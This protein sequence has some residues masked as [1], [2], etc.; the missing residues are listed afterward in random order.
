MNNIDWS[1][2][3]RPQSLAVLVPLLALLALIAQALQLAGGYT[4]SGELATALWRAMAAALL[5]AFVAVIDILVRSGQHRAQRRR[6]HDGEA[7][8]VPAAVRPGP[9]GELGSLLHSSVDY[10]G[11]Y[12][13]LQRGAPGL[14]PQCSGVLYLAGESD[15]QFAVG[16][17]W[18][19]EVGSSNAFA[20]GDCWAVRKGE[21]QFTARSAVA[22]CPHLD[23]P[24]EAPSLCVPVKAQGSVLGML[25]LVG[26]SESG[27]VNGLRPLATDVANA[28]GMSIANLKLRQTLR[29]LSVRDEHT[30]VFNR[31][32]LEESLKREIA[33]AQRKSRSLGVAICDVDGFERFNETYGREAGDFALR[34]IAQ[35]MNAKIRSS[36][37][38]A[39]YGGGQIALVL[40]E[41]PL[42]GVLMRANHLREAVFALELKHFDRALGK[43]S[44]S[45]GVALYPLH[46][47][48]AADLLRLAQA[49]LGRAKAAGRNRVEAAPSAKEGSE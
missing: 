17:S 28:L 23:Q 13:V 30:G 43:L 3:L 46:G 36:D 2:L 10:D 9:L 20:P 8:A 29:D 42:D 47:N 31:R 18:G 37:I 39:R 48:T 25:L 24:I 11:V 26:P 41:A 21:V 34:E 14:F 35:L 45:F 12:Q 38:A 1:S 4:D 32:Y 5:L 19:K 6:R 16:T 22:A 27:V 15:Q 7:A 44:V 40:P 49:A 33:T